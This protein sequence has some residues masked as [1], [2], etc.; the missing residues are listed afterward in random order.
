MRIGINLLYMIPRRNGG[1]ETYA[2]SLIRSLSVLD[3]ANEYFVFVNRESAGLELGCGSNF[4]KI[5]CNVVASIRS[6]RYGWEQFVFPIMLHRW[7]L[8]VVHSLGYVGPLFIN[9]PSV[10]TI[11][12]VNSV[13]V[14]HMVPA[15][16]RIP[17]V[18]LGR[19]IAKRSERV[20]TISQF[21]KQEIVKCFGIAEEKIRVVHL[22]PGWS[23]FDQKP[24]SWEQIK[25]RYSIR[26][27]YITA[28][29]GGNFPH[30]NLPRLFEA[31]R[32]MSAMRDIELLIIGALSTDLSRE[33][34]RN[35]A[36][37][38]SLG[39]VDTTD[40]A[41]ILAHG[42]LNV[43][44]SLYEGFG[45]PALEAQSAGSPLA[46]SDAGSLPEIAGEG[47]YYFSPVSVDSMSSAISRCLD[48][49][50]LRSRLIQKGYQNVER[51]SWQKTALETLAIY[52]EVAGSP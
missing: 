33:A 24:G 47:A 3:S 36:R 28:F 50:G 39:F 51:F 21:S 48:D 18:L 2:L 11:P 38:R 49:C 5:I 45:L 7:K 34:L 23:A 14:G 16:R 37:I 30:K 52:R 32:S 19:W 12:D 44:P 29:A 10:V 31:F 8:N 1:T 20:I 4:R 26:D 43:F 41:S 6:F 9:S 13:T 40:L 17:L 46:C 25:K 35:G 22:G 15:T 42:A 27:A